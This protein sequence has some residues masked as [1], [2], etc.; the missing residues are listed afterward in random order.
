MDF[1]IQLLIQEFPLM[2]SFPINIPDYD[3]SNKCP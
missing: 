1:I 3:P 2:T